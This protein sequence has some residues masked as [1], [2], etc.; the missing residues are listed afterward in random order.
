[1]RP[2]LL[3]TSLLLPLLIG[4]Q[5]AAAQSV[6][7]AT[8]CKLGGGL[9]TLIRV[10]LAKVLPG[11]ASGGTLAPNLRVDAIVVYAVD[12]PNNGQPLG[13][14]AFTG[15][16]LCT[17]TDGLLPA[18]TKYDID[19]TNAND[20]ISG[21][22]ILASEIETRVQ[23]RRNSNSAVELLMCLSTKSNNDCFRLFPAVGP[24]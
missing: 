10:Q 5:E 23:Y 18:Q 13:D 16:I 22:D 20:P 15:P 2:V 17:F 11:L 6:D 9:S 19:S 21:I 14:G 3:A 12:N 4:A 1:M 8:S 24:T 7:R